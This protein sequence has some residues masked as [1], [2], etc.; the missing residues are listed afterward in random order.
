VVHINQIQYMKPLNYCCKTSSIL[1]PLFWPG[2][3]ARSNSKTFSGAIFAS[4]VQF[5]VYSKSLNRIIV[6]RTENMVS[7][8]S[9]IVTTRAIA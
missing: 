8:I 9:S 4:Q 3:K 2:G 5:A 6:V 1:L 7:S